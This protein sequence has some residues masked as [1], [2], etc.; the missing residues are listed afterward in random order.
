MSRPISDDDL[1]DLRA[2]L[3]HA[4]E[5][6]YRQY[7]ELDALLAL[8]DE[9]GAPR[10]AGGGTSLTLLERLTALLDGAE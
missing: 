7:V 1:R 2:G 3:A 8:L 4:N 6:A 9:R 5:Q 10:T